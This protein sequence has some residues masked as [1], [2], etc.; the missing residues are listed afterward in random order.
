MKPERKKI[1]I[2]WSGG[3]DSTCLIWR[4]LADDQYETVLAGYVALDNNPAKT[5]SE[6]W[7]ISRLLPLLQENDKFVWLGVLLRVEFVKTNPNLAFKQMPVW[8]LAAIE[9]IHPPVDEIGIGYINGPAGGPWDASH[10]LDDLRRIYD[11]Y[12]PLLHRD[13]PALVFPMAHL[14]KHEVLAE[15]PARLAALCVYCEDPV[16]EG[17]G[18][19][20]CGKCRLCLSRESSPVRLPGAG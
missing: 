10:H 14:N 7:A 11:A 17:D 8:I 12:R 19:R 1:L 18:F 6:L 20:P 3:V 2:L 16:R 9:A 4:C 15:L 13:P 5:E